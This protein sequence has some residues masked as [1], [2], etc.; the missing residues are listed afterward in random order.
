MAFGV[1]PITSVVTTPGAPNTGMGGESQV[2]LI[3]L[4]IAAFAAIAGS[5]YVYYLSRR[6]SRRTTAFS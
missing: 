3:V 1:T 4:S 6:I 5:A 2:N